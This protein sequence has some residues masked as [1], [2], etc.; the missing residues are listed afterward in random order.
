MKMELAYL[1]VLYSF[2][3]VYASADNR[4]LP[5]AKT[6]IGDIIGTTK[7]VK[8]FGNNMNVNRFFGI[9]FAEAP[10]GELRF[11]KPVPKK[12]LNSPFNAFKDGN[13]CLQLMFMRMSYR[14][15]KEIPLGEDCL[16]LNIYVP[17]NAHLEERHVP[18]DSGDKWMVLDQ[19][20][21][22]PVMVWLY[23][24]GFFGGASN[25]YVADTLAAFGEVIVVTL[26]YRVSI[27]GFLCTG[28]EHAPG[29][30][31]LWDQHVAIKWVHD[32]IKAFG[33]DPSKVTIFGESAG[34]ASAVYQSL[35]EGNKGLFQRAIA[36]SGSMT[37]HWAI[38]KTPKQD[39]ERLGNLVGCNYTDSKALV[40]CLKGKSPALLNATLN[41]LGNGLVHGIDVPFLPTVDGDF[42]KESPL[43]LLTGDSETSSNGRN[44]FASID[45]MS[46]IN[47]N[48]GICAISPEIGIDDPDHFEPNRTFYEETLL[49]IL[50]KHVYGEDLPRTVMDLVIHEYTYWGDHNDLEKRRSNY[51]SCFSHVL[52]AIPFVETVAR[53]RE[54]AK[55]SKNTYMYIFDIVPSR[56]VYQLPS[57]AEGVSHGDDLVYTF[58]EESDGVL[59]YFYGNENFQPTDYDREQAKYIMTLL[60]NFAKTG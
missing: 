15:D 21:G 33:G 16:F 45:F 5:V 29:N 43:E 26:N 46:S 53:H 55:T 48:E 27:W 44:M 6:D 60:S 8:V 32:N 40:D 1:K 49:P 14:E 28:D 12:R 50:M 36:Q 22:L 19:N 42:V 41:D 3:L 7:E 24:G 18:K 37:A 17:V 9:P 57:W 59:T 11:K 2:M 47:A 4:V 39:A 38:G 35:Y 30:Y 58:F 34:G 56:H 52:F 54:T 23:G 25:N 31:G 51:I 20:Q 13:A 10:V